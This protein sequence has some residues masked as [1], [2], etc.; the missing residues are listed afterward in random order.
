MPPKTRTAENGE[1][2]SVENGERQQNACAEVSFSFWGIG[3][4]VK[5]WNFHFICFYAALHNLILHFRFEKI[6]VRDSFYK[7]W[8]I[9]CP[10][11]LLKRS[12]S[13]YNGN[14][15]EYKI[16]IK[17]NCCSSVLF[18]RPFFFFLQA[19]QI[20]MD[21]HNFFEL[22]RSISLALQRQ[23]DWWPEALATWTP[24][25]FARSRRGG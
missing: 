12:M 9:L 17:Y 1:N 10:G 2:F 23:A 14:Y 21:L 5:Q 8:T 18:S 22:F 19:F 15:M 24:H 11:N 25:S 4:Q 6:C 7:Q 3:S 16:Y 13:N 20:Q